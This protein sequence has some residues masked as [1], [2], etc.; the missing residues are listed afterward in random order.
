MSESI[1]KSLRTLFPRLRDSLTANEFDAV[2]YAADRI[3]AEHH[4][5]YESYRSYAVRVLRAT[6]HGTRAGLT[7]TGRDLLDEAADLL[8]A[9]LAT[10]LAARRFGNQEKLLDELEREA[11]EALKSAEESFDTRANAPRRANDPRTV[12]LYERARTLKRVV[13]AFRET[14]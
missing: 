4:P 7:T 1:S 8:E 12:R 11:E 3:E 6:A 10:G 14:L 9:P 5:G 2:A 13:K